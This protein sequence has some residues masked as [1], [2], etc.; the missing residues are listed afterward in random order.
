[1]AIAFSSYTF[2]WSLNA[3]IT[4][5]AIDIELQG[6]FSYNDHASCMRVAYL[7]VQLVKG[8]SDQVKDLNMIVTEN[9]VRFAPMHVKCHKGKIHNSVMLAR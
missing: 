7:G 3:F 8:D 4:G 9:N 2:F 1:M 6:Q 5:N